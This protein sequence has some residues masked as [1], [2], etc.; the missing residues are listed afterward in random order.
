MTTLTQIFLRGLA[1]ILPVALT[2]YLIY[3]LATSS[4]R[5]LGGLIQLVLPPHIYI[6]GMGLLAG[7]AL[8][9]AAGLLVQAWLIRHELDHNAQGEI[10]FDG[11]IEFRPEL[12]IRWDDEA[13]DGRT[14]SLTRGATRCER[15]RS[16]LAG[17]PSARI[18]GR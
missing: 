9:F 18:H 12:M 17:S 11:F 13:R 3:W 15:G 6:P 4:E 5:F 1:A 16:T 14:R 8:T 7:V 2:L 10:E